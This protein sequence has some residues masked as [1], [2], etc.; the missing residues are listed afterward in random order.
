MDCGET[1]S[2]LG[3]ESKLEDFVEGDVVQM[4]LISLGSY[5]F[6]TQARR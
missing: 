1:A 6:D 2:F 4:K 5:S 3:S